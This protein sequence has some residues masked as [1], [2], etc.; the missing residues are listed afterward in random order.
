MACRRWHPVQCGSLV[1]ATSVVDAPHRIETPARLLF[2]GIPVRAVR[3]R[4]G[5]SEDRPRRFRTPLLG[6]IDRPSVDTTVLRRLPSKPSPRLRIGTAKSRSCSALAVPPGF[7]GLLRS[8]QIRRST[9]STVRGFVAPRSRPWGSPR[10]GLPDSA[11]QPSLRPEGRGPEGPGIVPCGEDPS[12]RSPPRQ[13][14]TM[15][16]PRLV[17]SDAVAYTGWRSLS[18]L[19]PRS[20]PCH[21][22]ALHCSR[23]QGFLPPRSPLRSRDVAVA[24]RSMLP[25][26]LDRLVPDAAARIALPS[27]R[28]TFRLAARTASASPHPNVKGRQGVSALS[29]SLRSASGCPRRDDRARS[30]WL[31]R[32]SRRSRLG[33]IPDGPRRGCQ[34]IRPERGSTASVRTPEGMRFPT[35]S[36]RISEE[37]RSRPSARSEERRPVVRAPSLRPSAVARVH[38]GETARRGRAHPEA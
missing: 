17:L 38:D 35:S 15:P 5:R 19:E 30:R 29:G 26:A 12:K 25:W 34:W 1:F 2:R 16:S 28:W 23:P 7:S 18:P 3:L 33:R 11:S 9:R 22:G 24:R 10:F 31:R 27:S 13:P 21:H 6:F 36:R 4:R 14:S 37:T 8:E 20:L 32:I